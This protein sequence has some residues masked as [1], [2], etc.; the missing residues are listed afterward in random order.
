VK[1]LQTLDCRF[2]IFFRSYFLLSAVS[3]SG[4]VKKKETRKR[5]PLPSGLVALVELMAIF[6]IEITYSLSVTSSGPA[7]GRDC[8]EKFTKIKVLDTFY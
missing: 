6:F 1:R 5:M 7:F 8:I 4:L 2:Q 3:F